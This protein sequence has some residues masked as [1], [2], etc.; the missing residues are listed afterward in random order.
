MKKN[1][2]VF[3]YEIIN[4]YWILYFSFCTTSILKI[5]IIMVMNEDQSALTNQTKKIIETKEHIASKTLNFSQ[6]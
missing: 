1:E 4:M 3:I 5:V 6:K 2:N